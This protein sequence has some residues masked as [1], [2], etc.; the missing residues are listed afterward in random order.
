MPWYLLLP[1]SSA[2]LY[3]LASIFLKRGLR[4][5][6]TME[7]SFHI[8]NLAV[9]LIFAPLLLLERDPVRWDLWRQPLLTT[10]SFFAGT[11]L[12]FAAMRSAD[13]SLVTPLMGTKVVFV[14]IGI[15]ILAGQGPPPALWV[16][17]ILTAA[18]VFLMGF[19]DFRKTAAGHGIAI[20][21]ALL[22]A[23]V[24]G[25]CDVF[26]RLWSKNFG[27]MTFLALS[28]MGVGVLSLLVWLAKGMRPLWPRAE[29][30]KPGVFAAAGAAIIGVQAVSMGL[31]VSYFDDATGINVV[32]A[33]RGL[34]SI[35]LI[36]LAGPLLG[37]HERHTAGAAYRWRV[38]G[39]VLV[40][41]AVVIAV[42]ARKN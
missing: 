32:Y 18:G 11:W 33:S 36:G 38:C 29:N 15:A 41:A 3:A 27:A 22:S 14:A 28:S 8:N 10:V 20:G 4:D 9:A 12:T 13:V 21:A 5:G 24:F 23:A 6:A 2:I 35:A 37:N 34:W 17:A 31:A 7:Q 30:A 1:L 19:R 42:L 16:A 40:T 25:V 39:S 26:V